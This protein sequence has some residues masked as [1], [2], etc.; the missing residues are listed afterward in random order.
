MFS[1]TIDFES[2]ILMRDF[3]KLRL[4]IYFESYIPG[5]SNLR[6]F[7]GLFVALDKFTRV[8]FSF[9]CYYI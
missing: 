2:A 6:L 4:T 8:P 1:L 5:V 3:R 7:E 9:L